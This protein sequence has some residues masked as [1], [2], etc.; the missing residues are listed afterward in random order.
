VTQPL[1]YFILITFGSIFFESN[2]NQ[3][4]FC[5]SFLEIIEIFLNP[6]GFLEILFGIQ[7]L[8]VLMYCNF[9]ESSHL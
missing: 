2:R 8:S 5:S 7:L 6:F 3:R 9:S 1:F 4:S